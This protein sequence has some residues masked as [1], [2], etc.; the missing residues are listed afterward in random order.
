MRLKFLSLIAS[1]LVLSVVIGSCVDGTEDYTYTADASLYAF[2]LDSVNGTMYEFTID[3]INKVV[4]NRDSMPVGAD[5][6]I[7]QILIDTLT[8][9][10]WVIHADTLVEEGDSINM[11]AA[12][13]NDNGMKF[14][15]YAGDGMTTCDYRIKVNV[16]TQD[17][18][19]LVWKNMQEV[20]PIF[21][22]EVNEGAQKSILLNNK[23][24]VYT[25]NTTYYST[26]TDINQ[27]GWSEGTVSGL[28][29]TVD[30]SSLINCNEA[31]YVLADGDLY[32][33][34]DGE[35]WSKVEALSGDLV[36]LIA[37]F[38]ANEE[39]G[40]PI[41]LSAIKTVE[42]VNTY[43]ATSD[44]A[45][46]TL[47]ETVPEDFPTSH[48]YAAVQTNGSG[49]DKVTIVGMPHYNEKATIPWFSL[50]GLGWASLETSDSNYRC[51][52]LNNPAIIFYGGQYYIMGGSFHSIF[53]SVTSIAWKATS[54]KFSMLEE[55]YMKGFYS[56]NIDKDNYI[57]IVWG[58]NGAT[59]EVWR[60]RLNRLGFLIQ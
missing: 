60:G 28:P 43:C 54:S 42:G 39:T 5:T 55:F 53:T 40:M 6:I 49:V 50:D 44:F 21:S 37:V 3:Q 47:G 31:L 32:T 46:W 57:W 16:H 35:A 27:Y 36:S 13:N 45:S 38:P 2:R 17:P 26:S 18:D 10:G 1:F 29:Q 11:L 9:T 4:Y 20:S 24:L 15:V 58:G 52:K 19:S 23:L 25:S 30:L 33:S 56:L 7:N 14:T 48:F 59:N 12:M 22:E 34:T 51:P 41:T 8:V